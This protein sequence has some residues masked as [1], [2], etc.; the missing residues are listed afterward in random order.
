MRN[1]RPFRYVMYVLLALGAALLLLRT[2]VPMM[3]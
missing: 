1:D 2:I 3:G